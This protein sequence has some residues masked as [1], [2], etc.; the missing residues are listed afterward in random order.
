MIKL[1]NGKDWALA[2][3]TKQMS[4]DICIIKYT[5][6]EAFK[7]MKPINKFVPFSLKGDFVE[8]WVSSGL[9]GYTDR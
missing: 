8:P 7:V 5:P 1:I 4:K 9:I 2:E 6:K 3:L